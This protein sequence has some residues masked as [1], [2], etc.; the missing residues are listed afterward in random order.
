MRIPL[1]HAIER[2]AEWGDQ[3]ELLQKEH[4]AIF[5]AI[6]AGDVDRAADATEAHIRRAS[7][8]LFAE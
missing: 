2:K 7:A 1:L 8:V 3:S 6:T 4:H 5:E